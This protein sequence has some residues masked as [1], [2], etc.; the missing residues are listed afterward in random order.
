MAGRVSILTVAAPAEFIGHPGEEESKK[1]PPRRGSQ[2]S[3]SY[4]ICCC[5][6]NL[7]FED[8]LRMEMFSGEISY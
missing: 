2:P 3:N 1:E 4:V 7:S 8:G 5:Y 6:R